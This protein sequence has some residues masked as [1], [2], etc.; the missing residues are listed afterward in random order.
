MLTNPCKCL[1]IH[2]YVWYENIWPVLKL[3]VGGARTYM[4]KKLWTFMVR[5]EIKLG[6]L[7][8]VLNTQF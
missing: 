1:D 3:D 7:Y 5:N 4:K 6:N 2:M 8:S